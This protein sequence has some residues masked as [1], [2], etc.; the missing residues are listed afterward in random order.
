[1]SSDSLLC[2]DW[3]DLRSA[4]RLWCVATTEVTIYRYQYNMTIAASD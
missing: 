2:D 3:F 4:P 1:M